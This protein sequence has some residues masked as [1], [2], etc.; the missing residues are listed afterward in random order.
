MLD[1]NLVF[2]G[3]N[4]EMLFDVNSLGTEQ[5]ADQDERLV[6]GRDGLV[7]VQDAVRHECFVKGGAPPRR[8]RPERRGARRERPWTASRP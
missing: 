4:G 8:P 7:V 1:G 5:I 2:S 6:D 3:R